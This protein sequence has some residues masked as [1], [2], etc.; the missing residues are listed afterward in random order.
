VGQGW[1]QF[2]QHPQGDARRPAGGVR[3]YRFSNDNRLESVTDARTAEFE[4]PDLWHLQE[5]V[6]TVLEGDKAHVETS[7]GGVAISVTPNLLSALLVSPERM[8]LLG[9]LN[10]TRHLSEN[11]QKTERYEI[12][13][14]KKWSIR[15]QHWSWSPLPCLSAIPITALAVSA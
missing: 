1:S 9:L 12:A 6:K 2:H 8:S 11:K 10:Y 15:W 3:I 14:W 7:P 4:S 5:V 13:L